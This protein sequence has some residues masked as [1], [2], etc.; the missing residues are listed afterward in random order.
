MTLKLLKFSAEWCTSCKN[1]SKKLKETPLD[2]IEVEEI[3]VE[4]DDDIAEKYSIRNLPTC[5]LLGKDD[6]VIKR[7]SGYYPDL[8]SEINKEADAYVQKNNG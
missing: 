6:E 5:V 1:L 7:F 8:L 3:D 2:N 4:K